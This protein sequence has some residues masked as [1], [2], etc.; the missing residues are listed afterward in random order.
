[1]KENQSDYQIVR[2]RG[3]LKMTRSRKWGS[4]LSSV[5]LR[6]KF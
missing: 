3:L 5:R 1:M 2:N 6:T 4:Q